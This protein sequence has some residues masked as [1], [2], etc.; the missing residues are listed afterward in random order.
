MQLRIR[1]RNL[2]SA[3]KHILISTLIQILLTQKKGKKSRSKKWSKLINS[4]LKCPLP[5]AKF[6]A[7]AN[8]WLPV[9]NNNVFSLNNL[10]ISFQRQKMTSNKSITS[11]TCDLTKQTILGHR[12]HLHLHIKEFSMSHSIQSDIIKNNYNRSFW[13]ALGV[14][15]SRNYQQNWSHHV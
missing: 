8:Y 3:L 15:R 9:N 13:L 12:G 6:C 7:T 11:T 4:S 10:H 5:S 14:F 2:N 1:A